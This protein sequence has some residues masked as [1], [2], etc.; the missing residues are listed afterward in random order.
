MAIKQSIYVTVDVVVITVTG[1][2]LLIRRA[3]EPYAGLWALPGGFV[4]DDEDLPE[5]AARELNEETGLSF[6]AIKLRQAGAYGKPGRDPRFRTVSIVF[7]AQ[8]EQEA[9]VA[10]A[11]DAAEA[12]WFDIQA[13]PPLAFDHDEILGTILNGN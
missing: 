4:E 13:L 3:N 9:V 11:D 10:G 12:Q 2:L 8:L 5:A 6:P 7:I 1:K